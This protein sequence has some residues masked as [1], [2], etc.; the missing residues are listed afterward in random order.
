[1]LHRKQG[2]RKSTVDGLGVG[3]EIEAVIA[4]Q[5]TPSSYAASRGNCVWAMWL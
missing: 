3:L 1:M 4:A 5:P 2:A